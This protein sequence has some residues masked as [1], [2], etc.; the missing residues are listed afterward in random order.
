MMRVTRVL[1][2][3][4]LSFNSEEWLER[5]TTKLSTR[6][7]EVLIKPI[8]AVLVLTIAGS[9]DV[10]AQD[11]RSKVGPTGATSITNI[12]D[13]DKSIYGVQWGSSEDEFITR[14]GN[15]TGYIRLNGS[16][17]AME[18]GKSH[19]FIFTASKLSGLRICMS[20]LDWKLSQSILTITPFD[21][22]RWQLSNGISRD[23]NLAEVR[24][25]VGDRL[26]DERPGRYQLYF[27]SDN[28]RIELEFSRI[29][30]E[31]DRDES[32]KV[33]GIYIRQAGS[34]SGGGS[35]AGIQTGSR[36]PG[37][38][39][40]PSFDTKPVAINYVQVRYTEEARKNKVQGVVS[41]SILVGEDGAVKEAKII[42]GLPDGLNEQALAAANQL[43][44]KP[45]MRNGKAV[46]Y[47]LP[48][49]MEFHLR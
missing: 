31:G 1:R 39:P 4:R 6:G 17:T 8:L 11:V 32:Y 10:G 28:A 16:D 18:Y 15:P 47:W 35:G 3:L 5:Q 40:A 19:A 49:T 33:Y 36:D 2:L 22:I 44:F 29:T 25:I 13:P 41:M 9:L 43:R 38:D 45:A 48:I 46:S 21:G 7:G 42:K 26:R 23:M 12:I 24:K 34:P 20:V 30:N 27:N 14:F 37:T